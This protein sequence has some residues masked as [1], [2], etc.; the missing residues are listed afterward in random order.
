ML[1]NNK[2]RETEQRF[3]EY[4]LSHYGV[5]IENASDEQV[6][7]AL[8][9][10]THELL[11]EKKIQNI[12]NNST[13]YNENIKSINLSDKK[14]IQTSTHSDIEKGF[15]KNL[16]DIKQCRKN[17]EDFKCKNN[18]SEDIPQNNKSCD[19]LRQESIN[20]E[21]FIQKNID[22]E[23]FRQDNKNLDC[24]RQVESNCDRFRQ[25]YNVCD[26]FRQENNCYDNF[27]QEN[28]RCDDFRRDNNQCEKFRQNQSNLDNNVFQNISKF[29]EKI[30]DYNILKQKISNPNLCDEYINDNKNY[31]INCQN[32]IKKDKKIQYYSNLDDKNIE[33]RA[34]YPQNSNNLNIKC[35]N[36][37]NLDKKIQDKNISEEIIHSNKNSELNQHNSNKFDKNLN[38]NLDDLRLNSESLDDLSYKIN[39]LD[40]IKLNDNYFDESA[41]Y[42]YNIRQ[43]QNDVDGTRQENISSDGFLQCG[44][45]LESIKQSDN[46]LDTISQSDMSLD[47]CIKGSNNLDGIRHNNNNLNF[48][49]R[50]YDSGNERLASQRVVHYLSIEF[51]IGKSLF[52]NLWNL[53]LDEHFRL[54]LNAH[55]KNIENVY[56]VEK[57]AGL[58]NGGLGRLASCYLESMAKCGYRSYGHSIKY[59]FGL[60]HQKIIDGKQEQFPDEW[61]RTGSVWLGERQDKC[62]EISIGGNIV[63]HYSEKDGL[64]FEIVNSTDILAVPFDYIVSAHGTD[65]SSTLR[66]WEA[67]A[68]DSIN[69]HLFDIGEINGAL[70]NQTK[71]S[72]INKVLYPND[73][74]AKGRE[75]RLIQQYFL[76]SAVVQSVFREFFEKVLGDNI[77]NYDFEREFRPQINI[78]DYETETECLKNKNILNCYLKSNNICCVNQDDYLETLKANRVISKILISKNLKVSKKNL[79]LFNV[80]IDKPSVRENIV[81]LLAFHINDTHPSLCIPEIMRVLIDDYHFGWDDSWECLTK[82]VSYTNHTILSESLEIKKLSEIETNMPRIALIIKEID[83]RFRKRLK[84][85]FRNDYVKIERLA[86]I[87]GDNVYMANLSILSSYAVNGVSKIHSDILKTRLFKDYS[88]M[89]SE[90]F[91]NITNGISFRRWL[92]ESNPKL[93]DLIVG[94]VGKSVYENANI[95][96]GLEKFETSE[97]VLSRLA[98]VKFEN[99]V[100]FSKY[101]ED[102]LKIKIDPSFRFDV[103]AKRIHE[104]KRQLMNIMKVIYLM[105]YIKDNPTKEFTKQVFI[106][107]GKS[108]SSY[109][110]AK[111]IIELI[112]S[113]SKEIEK[114]EILSKCLKVVFLENY[115]VSMAELLMTATEV[116]EQISVAGREA[117]GT[118]NMKATVN[119][120][121]MLCTLDGANIEICDRCGHEN[122]F[123]FGLS[124]KEVENKIEYG[125]NA[126][127]YYITSERVR[128]VIDRMS[129]GFNGEKFNDI[130]S[131][132]LGR[133]GER[134]V[135]MCLADFDSYLDAHFEMD[136]VYKNK[137]EWNRRSL[138]TIA[139]MGY[140]SSDRSI[141]EYAKYIWKL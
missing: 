30:K 77:N 121:L 2:I 100:R 108:A 38:N 33:N 52:N 40:N 12:L 132:L 71:I 7:Y 14:I 107:A 27:R 67:R 61:L 88:Y 120:A 64:N 102:N 35:Q 68:K 138:H 11:Y 3:V 10:V 20:D 58:G 24:F 110:V 62:V 119:G 135:Y 42:S 55:G 99:K 133:S 85:V 128:Y 109:R 131:Y 69:L 5:S 84:E 45:N 130:A 73:S 139:N 101:A 96:K 91:L 75:I 141:M 93:R 140:F 111:R 51:L 59:E 34:I 92:F 63:E 134:D 39:S 32:D 125:Y 54:L 21:K 113:V 28:N 97:T 89:F 129:E 41:K 23:N 123:E 6:Y 66:L 72:A 22:N 86:V 15:S 116:S 94:L 136:R 37:I 81:K 48:L 29:D 122:M 87:S 124:A 98:M 95:L 127:E 83:K 106:F 118:G 19:R 104:Y 112:V 65:N 79:E 4:L 57:D 31:Y 18:N 105:K 26:E 53:E 56:A 46:N 13:F 80:M 114:D 43:N 60:F 78:E 49:F 17:I 44:N 76:V 117:S 103:Q 115:N 1:S 8:S 16:E 9:S 74:T 25:D 90:K 47:S 137:V 126:M 82:I 50:C 70:K 36:N